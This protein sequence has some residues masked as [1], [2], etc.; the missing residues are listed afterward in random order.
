MKYLEYT[1]RINK[2]TYKLKV[3]D[4][5]YDSLV[6]KKFILSDVGNTFEIRLNDG[7]RFRLDRYVLMVHGIN[8]KRLITSHI[9]NDKCNFTFDNIAYGTTKSHLNNTAIV[10]VQKARGRNY[11][12]FIKNNTLK[13]TFGTYKTEIEAAIAYNKGMDILF[14]PGKHISNKLNIPREVYKAIYDCIVVDT[15]QRKTAQGANHKL[16]AT[17][18]VYTGVSFDKSRDKWVAETRYKGAKL[19]I[20]RYDNEVEAAQAY[21]E[22]VLLIYGNTAKLNPV[23]NPLHKVIDIDKIIKRLNTIKLKV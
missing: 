20:G 1:G 4:K 5:V 22:A 17:T 21:N 9:D 8:I 18:S 12:A 10:G 19:F 3:D 23:P 14:G 7:G 16:K 2:E 6:G 15:V 13:V 11:R